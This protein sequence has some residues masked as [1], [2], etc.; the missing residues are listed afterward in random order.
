M[1][2]AYGHLFAVPQTGLRFFTV[3]GPWGRPDMAYFSFAEA[4]L[5]GKPI[6]VYDNGTVRRDFTYIDDIVL[7]VIGALD[8]PP[9]LP[10]EPGSPPVRILNI[11]NHRSEPITAVIALL[12]AGLERRAVIQYTPR[13]AADVA[14]TW[15]N[16]DAIAA[17]TD[18]APNTP[19]SVGLP[20]FVAWFR[21][22]KGI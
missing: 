18:F 14:D 22:W 21:S 7:G 4:I 2:H 11:G 8:H 12:E 15:A 10:A 17:L 19:L 5:A 3:Y 1:S 9:S 20:R 16:V 6:T 13:P